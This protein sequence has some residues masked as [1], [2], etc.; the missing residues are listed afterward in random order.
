MAQSRAERWGAEAGEGLGELSGSVRM[1]RW[2]EQRRPCLWSVDKDGGE[3][4]AP[5]TRARCAVWVKNI[6][7]RT[8]SHCSAGKKQ[9]ISRVLD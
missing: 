9:L 5:P 1:E 2:M 3:P 6:P 8:R 4:A 7:T